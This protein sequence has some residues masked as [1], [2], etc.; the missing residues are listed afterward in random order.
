MRDKTEI[1]M[2]KK[3]LFS[4]VVPVFNEEE[5]IQSFYTEINK[6]LKQS[7][8][9]PKTEIIFIDDGSTDNSLKEINSL[10]VRDKRVKLISF[11]RNQGVNTAFSAGLDFASGN[12]LIFLDVDNQ[13]PAS[14]IDDFIEGWKSG[15]KIIF[16]KRSNYR[17]KYLYRLLTIFFTKLINLTSNLKLDK[18]TSYVCMIDR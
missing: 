9:N 10:V 18:D 16:A 15:E 1:K 6:F 12:C 2:S 8:H 5:T 14:I 7:K 11:T 4:L 13:Y 3:E 17:T